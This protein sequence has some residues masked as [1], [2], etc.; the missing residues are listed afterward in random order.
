MLIA[1]VALLVTAAVL[2]APNLVERVKARQ[3][4]TETRRLLQLRDRLADS[5]E[6]TQQIPSATNWSTSLL[7][8]AAADQTTVAQTGLGFATDTNLTRVFLVDPALTSGLLPYTQTSAGLTG[9]QTNL[10][11]SAGRVM[12]VSNRKRGLTLPVVSGSPSSNLFYGLWNWYC[13]PSTLAPPSGFSASWSKQGDF[14][15]V[16]RL[17]LANVFQR[18]TLKQLLYGVGDTNT[19]SNLVTS[20][21]TYYFLRGTRLVLAETNGT[22]KRIHVVNRDVSFDFST[23][24]TAVGPALWYRFSETNGLVATNSG[25]LG[26]SGNGTYQNGTTLNVAG[27]RAPTNSGYSTNN[28]AAQFDGSN[29]IMTGPSGAMN[30]LTAFTLGGWFKKNSATVKDTDLFGQSDVGG[31]T[32]HDNNE[33]EFV[34]AGDKVRYTSTF[35]VGTWYHVVGVAN[36]STIRIYV[37]GSLAVSDNKSNSN[38]GSNASTFNVGDNVDQDAT[39]PGAIDEVVFYKSAL[40]ATEINQIYLGTLP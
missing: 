33:I 28:T 3:R 23:T 2:L 30:N 13:D 26:A 18:I 34:A 6:R 20:Q 5:I 22:L 25:S 1:A 36:G 35:S 38:Y 16:Q 39:F 10:L 27:P 14:L 12:L 31:F 32:W 15:E 9:S 4:D 24:A 37:N 7:P 17:N 8:F 29:D 21:T 40:T 19:A 11:G